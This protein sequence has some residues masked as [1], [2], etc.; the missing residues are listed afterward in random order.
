VN[1]H[2]DFSGKLSHY[3]YALIAKKRIPSGSEKIVPW[4]GVGGGYGVTNLISGGGKIRAFEALALA[5]IEVPLR[6]NIG[7]IL[8]GTYC[9]GLSED[10]FDNPF[11]EN[12]S[13][14][15]VQDSDGNPLEDR[16]S[17]FEIRIGVTIRLRPRERFSHH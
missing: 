16:Y 5:Q 12:V 9:A 1:I 14:D 11:L 8:E 15:I 10:G 6:G 13:G 2:E 7:L 17:A 3:D 4:L